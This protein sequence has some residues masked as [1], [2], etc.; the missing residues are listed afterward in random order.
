MKRDSAR[1][2][3]RERE[4]ERN[5]KETERERHTERVY[6]ES[7]FIK[8]FVRKMSVCYVPSGCA[9]TWQVVLPL[10]GP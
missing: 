7:Y 5:E 2:R 6:Y 4:R 1:A 9:C 8:K 10:Q 3:A